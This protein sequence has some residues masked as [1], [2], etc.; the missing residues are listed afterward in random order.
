VL[1]WS[2]GSGCETEAELSSVKPEACCE[3]AAAAS[4]FSDDPASD[5]RAGTGV[6]REIP[7]D[8]VN[9]TNT[10]QTNKSRLIPISNGFL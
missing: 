6:A 1:S 5:C 3:V 8:A 10:L 4:P 9:M 7:L 2:R